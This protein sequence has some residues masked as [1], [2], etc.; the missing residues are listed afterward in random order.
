MR[1][2]AG[3]TDGQVAVFDALSLG[4]VC[5]FDAVQGEDSGVGDGVDSGAGVG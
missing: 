5:S 2:V 4:K 3:C 1:L